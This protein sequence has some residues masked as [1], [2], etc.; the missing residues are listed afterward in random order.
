MARPHP[1]IALTRLLA[2]ALAIAGCAG[3]GA[4]DPQPAPA[5]QGTPPVQAQSR[6][7]CHSANLAKTELCREAG[8][9]YRDAVDVRDDPRKPGCHIVYKDA[10]CASGGRNWKGDQC[11]GDALFEWTNT[12]CHDASDADQPFYFCDDYC[13]SRGFTK[14]EC[15]TVE[16]VC[17]PHGSAF[18]ECTGGRSRGRRRTPS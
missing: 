8:E 11:A 1:R 5:T 12:A 4:A 10:Q 16:D 2:S 13:K 14:G 6:I 7:D 18:C 3:G 15:T 9:Y 17:Q